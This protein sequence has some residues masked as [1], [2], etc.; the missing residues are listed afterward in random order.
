MVNTTAPRRV[1]YAIPPPSEPVQHLILPSLGA[2]RNGRAS[3]LV[4]PAN[5]PAWSQSPLAGVNPAQQHP[6]HRLGVASLALDA[7]T[8]LLG[9]DSPEG[10]LYTGGR[11]GLVISWELGAHMRKRSLEAE[12][13]HGPGKPKRWDAITGW[14]D[15]DE[16]DEE[17]PILDGD[18]LGQTNRGTAKLQSDHLAWEDEWQV[19][20]QGPINTVRA[21]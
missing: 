3:P 4:V 15:E 20:E 9:R 21:L 16:S 11:D 12:N 7:A 8:Q 2:P 6:R 5:P 10:L 17:S 13:G 19:D 18:V 14:A 1:S